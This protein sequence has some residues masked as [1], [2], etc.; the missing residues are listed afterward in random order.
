MSSGR[1]AVVVPSSS[2][3][4]STAPN[5][6]NKKLA[7][8]SQILP[9]ESP[10]SHLGLPERANLTDS[11]S[12]LD[13]HEEHRLSPSMVP[14]ASS[15]SDSLENVGIT[16]GREV[17]GDALSL[18]DE[19][20]GEIQRGD[21]KSDFFAITGVRRV[22]AEDLDKSNRHPVAST[23]S[24][25]V[26]V[27]K[28]ESGGSEDSVTTP[29]DKLDGHHQ[30]NAGRA[31]FVV[32]EVSPVNEYLEAVDENLRGMSAGI[33]VSPKT[34]LIGGGDEVG[35]KSSSTLASGGG[36][37]AG[38]GVATNGAAS[39][40]LN[41]FRRVNQ[42]E[43]GRWTVRDSLVTE[44]QAESLTPNAKH[45]QESR[46]SG[47]GDTPTT[48]T[49]QQ[50]S[51]EPGLAEPI[52]HLTELG[53]VVIGGVDSISDRDSSS[54]PLDRSS[55]A[56]ET[57]SLSRNTSMSSILAPEKSVDGD[58]ILHA[59]TDTE[60]V[61]GG[62]SAGG[63]PLA[64]SSAGGLSQSSTQDHEDVV[65]VVSPQ[66]PAPSSASSSTTSASAVPP[67][68]SVTSTLTQ[69]PPVATSSSGEVPPPSSTGGPVREDQPQAMTAASAPALE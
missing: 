10:G 37:V 40:Q 27:E 22:D 61:A 54:I 3:T 52:P 45:Q 26:L 1:P 43:R 14:S 41:R 49:S 29:T 8:L 20:A 21:A 67:A 9:N 6:E 66:P 57:L 36:G 68:T 19:E 65:P 48:T 55:I 62:T 31:K 59:D 50:R 60:S 63:A 12:D 2:S 34:L 25:H 23:E 53:G 44:E 47:S 7:P 15:T 35:S 46:V 32:G 64:L 33:A 11:S 39:V 28:G 69:P 17:D 18:G 38:G 56:A 4:T 58:E 16:G 13:T 51:L 5:S 24:L 30:A 42:Y